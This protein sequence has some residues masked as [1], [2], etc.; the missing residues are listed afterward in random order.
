MPP[1]YTLLAA[2]GLAAEVL[3]MLTL[4]LTLT[5]TLITSSERACRLSTLPLLAAKGLAAEVLS[6]VR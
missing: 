2:K 4:T 5:L 1:K 3:S 6:V